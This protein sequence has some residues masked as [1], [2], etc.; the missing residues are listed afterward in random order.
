[1]HQ[2]EDP[3]PASLQEADRFVVFNNHHPTIT[4]VLVCVADINGIGGCINLKTLNLG[5]CRKLAGLLSSII[6]THDD[7]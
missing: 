2:F 1:M 6:T 7:C 5:Y 3:E 4:F